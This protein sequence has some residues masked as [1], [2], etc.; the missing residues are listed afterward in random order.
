M[1]SVNGNNKANFILT[2]INSKDINS[3]ENLVEFFK[4]NCDYSSFY[5][6]GIDFNQIAGKLTSSSKI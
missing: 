1:A 5:V 3:L 6:E 4:A 2:R